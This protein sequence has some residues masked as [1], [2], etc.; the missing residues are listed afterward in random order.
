MIEGIS[1]AVEGDEVVKV[2]Q[3]TQYIHRPESVRI[4]G[5]AYTHGGSF[6]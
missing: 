5:D 4:A 3:I 6:L 2:D 1:I